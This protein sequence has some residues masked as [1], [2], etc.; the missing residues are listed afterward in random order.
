MCARCAALRRLDID[1]AHLADGHACLAQRVVLDDGEV[2]AVAASA[3]DRLK[4]R[5]PVVALVPD[6]DVFVEADVAV[7]EIIYPAEF[8]GLGERA[9]GLEQGLPVLQGG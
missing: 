7:E 6:R 8:F 3:P 5:R 1:G 9:G 4:R 2:L